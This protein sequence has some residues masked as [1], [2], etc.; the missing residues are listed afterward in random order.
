MKSAGR[1]AGRSRG[2][3]EPGHP[4]GAPQVVGKGWTTV[5]V[6]EPP[7]RPHGAA[8]RPASSGRPARTAMLE[9]AARRVSGAWGSGHLLRAALLSAVLT[10]DGRVAVGAVRPSCCTAP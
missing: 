6:A 3:A 9:G 7:G 4:N 10:D 2:T 5:L 8:G 1:T